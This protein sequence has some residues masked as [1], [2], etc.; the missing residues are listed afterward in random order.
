L[1]LAKRRET[2]VLERI[3]LGRTFIPLLRWAQRRVV[4][5][6]TVPAE[7]DKMP[8]DPGK[9][10]CYALHV[11]QLSALLVLEEAAERLGLPRPLSPLA[12]PGLQ[13]RSSF[14]YLTR[15]GQP[16][17]LRPNPY[18]YS[19]RLERMVATSRGEAAPEL[20][21]VPVSIFWGRAPEKQESIL[22]ALFA[23]TWVVPGTFRQLVRLALHGRDTLIKF[24]EA[25]DLRRLSAEAAAEGL[26]ERTTLRRVARLLRAEFRREREL[27]VGP[28]L[29]HRQT[30]LNEVV[31]A[32]AVR[33]AV[34]DKAQREGLPVE[35]AELAAR[36]L[37]YGIASD[38]SYA[39]IRALDIA[40]TGL[41]NR[42][43]DG[44][45]VHRF[46]DVSAVGG[47][48]ELVYVPCHRSHID[49]LLL[50]YA[51]YHRGLQP[52]HIAA[53]ENLNLPVIGP[54]L[55]RGGAFFLRRSFKD[56]PLYAAVFAEYLHVIASR[57]FPIEYFIEGGRSRTGRMLAPKAGM[58]AMTVDSVLRGIKRPLV[59]VPVYIGYEQLLEGESYTAELSGKPKEKESVWAILTSLKK[60]KRR[61]GKVHVNIGEPLPLERFLDRHWP[62]WRAQGA[63]G[64]VEEH[65]AA[66]HRTVSA[67][68]TAIV[69]RINEALVVN[70]VNLVAVAM[71]GAPRRA[72]DA[73]R[74]AQQIDLLKQL[75][76]EV[77]Y[78]A[79]QVLTAMDGNEVI[80][81]AQQL[82]I[83]ERIAHPLG[84]IVRVPGRQAAALGYFR[85]NVLHAFAVPALIACLVAH[86]QRIEPH[87][88]MEIARRLFPFLRSELFLSWSEADL[89]RALQGYVAAFLRLQLIRERGPRLAAPSPA[90]RE[91]LALHSL[92]HAIH[93]P[94]ERYFVV[95][96]T[97]GRF[98]SGA[99]SARLL[100]DCCVLLAQRLAYLHEAA[101]PEFFDRASFRSIIR[102]LG[103]IGLASEE[104]GKL[105]FPPLLGRSADDAAYLLPHEARLAISH[106]T[107]LSEDDIV[108]A[109][110]ALN[111]K[112]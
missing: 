50:S 73:A 108:A 87:R 90:Q 48:A 92:A 67:L 19:K 11:R 2:N 82:G 22:R 52:P 21:I 8:F 37:A 15:S 104:D 20:Q 59:F 35:R 57:G 45:E 44:V 7:A 86:N 64:A 3:G 39:V 95:V 71:L 10:V 88:L 65:E 80:A 55:R 51:I 112:R 56:D 61:F 14:V 103:D 62:E 107:Q 36:R 68:A 12:A 26:D 97:L 81:Y 42:I 60:L 98:G 24:G 76:T 96:A 100:E 4:R 110:A 34:E 58:L 6:S 25:I 79:R 33:A 111:S 49:Y 101:G 105:H 109:V 13:E 5:Y 28:N 72:M 89:E 16:S 38:Y 29:S 46:E 85:N 43:Y 54:I 102:T 31:D 40:L 74:L 30:L 1:R 9:P 91:S 84:D 99:L 23:D 83:V 75:L 32:P 47:G 69:T 93:Q 18:E 66:R 63:P 70:P 41:W 77:P 27:A 94:L 106:V 78:S 17:P 53:G